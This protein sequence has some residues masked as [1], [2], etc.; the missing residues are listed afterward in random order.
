M[1]E[2]KFFFRSHKH[3]LPT[4]QGDFNFSE[5]GKCRNGPIE[6][7]WKFVTNET[8][9]SN[10]MHKQLSEINQMFPN[11][12]TFLVLPSSLQLNIGKNDLKQLK[13]TLSQISSEHSVSFIG[14]L[15]FKDPSVLCDR[16]HHANAIGRN[17]R[18]QDLLDQFYISTNGNL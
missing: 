7:P 8:A 4:L 16:A 9:L 15:P 1:D 6:D 12:Q 2:N 18:T 5:Y 10:W 11:A 13:K 17:F 14:Q 3:P